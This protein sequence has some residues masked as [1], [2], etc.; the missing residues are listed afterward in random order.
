MADEGGYQSET[1][2]CEE[3]TGLA[4]QVAA[5]GADRAVMRLSKCKDAQTFNLIHDSS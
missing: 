3:A 5:G 4:A 1:V 2:Y